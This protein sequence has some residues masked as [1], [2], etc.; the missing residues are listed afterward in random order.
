[1]QFIEGVDIP[2]E[3]LQAHT[4]GRLVLFVGAGASKSAPSSLPLF[5]ELAFQLG[6]LA[7]VQFTEAHGDKIDTYIGSLPSGFDAHRHAAALLRPEGSAPNDLH[8][9]LVRLACSGG[10]PRIVTTNFDGHLSTAA[11]DLGMELGDR[12]IGPALPLGRDFR[13]VVHLHGS[14]TRHH[15]E[16]IID[17][18][19]FGRAYFGDGWAPRFLQPMFESHVVLFVG[20]SL[21]DT[22]MR[23]LTLGLPSNT[24]RYALIPE[25]G[26]ER[27][28]L[29]RLQVKP[30]RYP[31]RDGKHL[32]LPAALEAWNHW[33]R[34]GQGE[35]QERIQRVVVEWDGGD[36]EDV[37]ANAPTLSAIDEGYLRAQI[38]TVEGAREFAARAGSVRWLEWADGLPDF[39]ALFA[40]TGELS[41]VALVLADWF[42]YRFVAIPE[43]SRSAM[44]SL[45]RHHQSLHPRLIHHLAF[46]VHQLEE[47]D[48]VAAQKWRVI[49]ATSIH[50]H[51]APA[52]LTALLP[53]EAKPE[54]LHNA[55]A[56]KALTP[57][58]SLG[59]SFA[60]F[61]SGDDDWPRAEPAWPLDAHDMKEHVGAWVG[62]QP[63]G[64][65][66]GMATLESALLSVYGMLDAYNGSSTRGVLEW[67]RSAIEAHPQDDRSNQ[68]DVIIDGL[69]DLGVNA[70]GSSPP[71]HERW[72]TF[73][74]GLF[75]R[76][77]LHL[78]AV[79]AELTSDQKVRWVLDRALLY[80][81]TTKH[82]TFQ[83]LQ[84]AVP[85]ASFETRQHLLDAVLVGHPAD[86]E[87]ERWERTRAYE[88]YNL[89]VWVTRADPEWLEAAEELTRIQTEHPDFAE[90]E[91]PDFSTWHDSG[92]WSAEPTVPV[93]DFSRQVTADPAKALASLGE[94]LA[95]YSGSHDDYFREDYALVRG[96]AAESPGGGLS[97]W[98]ATESDRLLPERRLGI[99]T[100]L[101]SGWTKADLGATGPAVLDRVAEMSSEEDRLYPVAEFLLDQTRK[102]VDGPDT[103]FMEGARRLAM[104]MWEEHQASFRPIAGAE[105]SSL[106]LNTW[107]GS[108]VYFW[109]AQ[110]QRRWRE[111]GDA[112][113]SLNEQERSAL[114]SLLGGPRDA[115]EAIWPAVGSELHFFDAAD[116]GFTDKYVLPL[117]T[118]Q[119]SL[120]Q[121]WESFLY[122]P[123][124]SLRLLKAGL[125]GAIVDNFGRLS[126]LEFNRLEG[127]FES[128]AASVVNFA[129]LDADERQKVLDAAVIGEEG[130]HAIDFAGAVVDQLRDDPEQSQEAWRAWLHA[131]LVQRLAGVPRDPTPEELA[132]WA[133]IVPV[134]GDR[135]PEAVDLFSG[136]GIGLKEGR[137]NRD[138][139]DETLEMYGRELV[140]HFAE[141]IQNSP[142]SDQMV[143]YRIRGLIETVQSSLGVA[144]AQPL[145][146]AAEERGFGGRGFPR[147]LG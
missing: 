138:F 132:Q 53:F 89:L 18:R 83:V 111:E 128:L 115:L 35:H 47:R 84:R 17:D 146:R 96:M 64:A 97:L 75:R 147:R 139:P 48:P 71:L 136:K 76:L 104:S 99:R 142:P 80:D 23:Y 119:D 29:L 44:A 125:L 63:A 86:H 20:Y 25:D 91:H 102:L 108:L 67:G 26:L 61:G 130:R 69:R 121:A 92:T 54:S 79:S 72:W 22:V 55:L 41:E 12:W 74:F 98:S 65:S 114:S 120:R 88:I 78:I 82:E 124:C 52:S 133:E 51:S 4:D 90:R 60:L 9:A 112:W 70:T 68:V 2:D 122:H 1:M 123:K 134:L 36:V 16:L 14:L 106:A 77:A 10:A 58:L 15:D 85:S 113:E 7:R 49:L 31:N 42:A 19:D 95:G 30:I 8:R 6:E 66:V 126:T 93:S 109:V 56:Q 105:P 34:M 81:L 143:S 3:V 50:G 39:N 107:P 145:V 87:D 118:H 101:V 37:A 45:R 117:F 137:F 33:S 57:F 32:M 43:L 40:S 24:P 73:G 27:A 131:H 103:E 11:E 21:T 5:D 38:S 135:I 144:A 110:I 141:R 94:G 59:S 140:G 28:E 129:A 46:A 100:A 62:A 127:Q 13:G 116:P